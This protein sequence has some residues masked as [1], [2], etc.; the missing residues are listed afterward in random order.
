MGFES[1]TEVDRPFICDICSKGF[2]RLEHK[3]RHI[4]TH[5]GEKPHHC[6][7]KGCVKK[8]SRSDELK[9]HLK[10]HVNKK[11]NRASKN[12]IM[13]RNIL[14][15]DGSFISLNDYHNNFITNIDKNTLLK[16]KES[17]AYNSAS[18]STSS[19]SSTAGSPSPSLSSWNSS[20]HNEDDDKLKIP[21]KDFKKIKSMTDLQKSNN[22]NNNN[23]SLPI[24]PNASRTSLDNGSTPHSSYTNLPSSSSSLA[25]ISYNEKN[26]NFSFDNSL[27]IKNKS[28][29]NGFMRPNYSGFICSVTNHS[30]QNHSSRLSLIGL[31]KIPHNKKVEFHLADQENDSEDN[32]PIRNNNGLE[33]TAH[34]IGSNKVSLPSINTIFAQIEVFNELKQNV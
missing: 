10:I 32:E 9:R 31:S 14:T 5:T 19:A 8:F 11:K 15:P 7:F 20:K 18:S 3:K 34:T 27:A 13:K 6:T 2:R 1:V 28:E 33:S 30:N 23:L 21:K 25:S 29:L 17:H 24:S 16:I 12:R 26:G 22:N 4:R